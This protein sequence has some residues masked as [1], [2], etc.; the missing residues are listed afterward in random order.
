RE[1]CDFRALRKGCPFSFCSLSAD[2]KGLEE[3][4]GCDAGSGQNHLA[5]VPLGAIDAGSPPSGNQGRVEF[6]RVGIGARQSCACP[7]EIEL[8]LNLL[9][10]AFRSTH[11]RIVSRTG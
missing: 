9:G 1:R 11:T 6:S 10:I 5:S 7:R 8:K 3:K 2:Q 4:S